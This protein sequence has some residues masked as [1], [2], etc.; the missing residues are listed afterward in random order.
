MMMVARMAMTLY[1]PFRDTVVVAEGMA[2]FG[3]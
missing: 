2:V 1:P 3:G